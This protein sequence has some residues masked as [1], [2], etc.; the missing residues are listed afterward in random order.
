MHT[1]QPTTLPADLSPP[2]ALGRLQGSFLV[3]GIVGLALLAVGFFVDRAHFF[4]AWLVAWVWCVSIALGCMGLLMLHHMTHG[5]WGLMIRRPLEAASRTLPLLVVLFLPL[6]AGL[7]DLYHWSHDE[8]VAADAI[9]TLKSPYLNVP[10]FIARNVLYFAIWLYFAWALNRLSKRQDE[11]GDAKTYASLQAHGA[12]GFLVL[13]MTSTFAAVDWI[14]SLDPHWFSSLYGLW[15]FAGMG[16][17]GLTFA[18]LVAYWL[19]GREPMAALFTSRHFHDYGKL[20][21][22]FTMLWAYLSFSQYLLI[23]SGNLP[24]EIPFYL[25]RL[26]GA[27]S[28]VSAVLLLAHFVFPFLILLSADVKH[29]ARTLVKVAL[30]V[31]VMRWVDYFWNV[32]PTLQA[33]HD[34]GGGHGWEWT[35]MWMDVA[36]LVGLG[37]VFLWY[38][39]RQLAQRPLLPKNDPFLAE[40][41]A[42]E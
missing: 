16:L 28:V 19:S 12:V 38:F 33:Q 31:L 9:L 2:A 24:E 18:I 23:W 32:A 7:H 29:R 42:H 15:F 34:G 35:G 21:F 1:A 20:F 30:W 14:M 22:A 17:S 26:G 4:Q 8:A 25:R 40:V 3:A 27:W 39:A 41:L 37:G 10:F 5:A 6:L 13:A 36:A 11:R